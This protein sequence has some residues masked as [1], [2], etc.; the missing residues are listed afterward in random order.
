MKSPTDFAADF[1][2]RLAMRAPLPGSLRRAAERIVAAREGVLV[3]CAT[4]RLALRFAQAVARRRQCRIAC[5]AVTQG[6]N[7]AFRAC[8]STPAA[9]AREFAGHRHLP[10][11][12][13][14]FPDQIVP[15]SAKPLEIPF[16]DGEYCFSLFEPALVLRHRPAVFALRSSGAAGGAE[17]VSVDYADLI[18][19]GAGR[20]PIRA[21][22]TRLMQPLERELA[23]GSR[24]W[25]AAAVFSNK[26]VA[27]T[28]FALEQELRELEC[29]LRCRL[30]FGSGQGRPVHAALSALGR[31]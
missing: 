1:C 6:T 19:Q 5:G 29:L 14:S 28:R 10:C 2:S 18:T 3:I 12:V 7:A 9:I 15:V 16:L 30:M 31:R 8:V 22:L 13:I 24:G 11:P 17:L 25:L 21:L 26:S 4:T 27:R 23:A 20:V